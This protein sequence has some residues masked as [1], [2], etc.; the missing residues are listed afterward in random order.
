MAESIYDQIEQ[1]MA[2]YTSVL[3]PMLTVYAH[4][5]QAIAD[6]KHGRTEQID[7]FFDDILGELNGLAR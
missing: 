1:D 5:A 2:F 6:I 7:E 4:L 3:E